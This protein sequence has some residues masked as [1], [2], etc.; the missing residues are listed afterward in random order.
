[1]RL[2]IAARD[3]SSSSSCRDTYGYFSCLLERGERF[4]IPPRI[5]SS[6]HSR[7]EKT[8]TQESFV[9]HISKLHFFV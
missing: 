5:F 8:E 4:V 7:K 1:M 6:T 2:R 3:C 9:Y